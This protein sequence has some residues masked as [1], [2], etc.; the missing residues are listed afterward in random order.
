[1][2]YQSNYELYIEIQFNQRS[3]L[4]SSVNGKKNEILDSLNEIV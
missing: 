3:T 4:N 1:M 2:K